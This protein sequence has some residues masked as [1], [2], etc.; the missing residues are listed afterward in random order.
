MEYE[1]EVEEEDDERRSPMRKSL[2][3]NVPPYIRFLPPE[4]EYS[5]PLCSSQP[6]VWKA[7]SGVDQVVGDCVQHAGFKVIEV[8]LRFVLTSTFLYILARASIV[9]LTSLL[10]PLSGKR[11][12]IWRKRLMK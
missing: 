10:P 6:L 8:L 9:G 5:Q 2:F 3:P 12:E 7:P 4:E 11:W 1:E